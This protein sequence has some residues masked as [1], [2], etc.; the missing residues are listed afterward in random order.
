MCLQGS[1]HSAQK[2]KQ[3]NAFEVRIS[4]NCCSVYDIKVHYEYSIREWI[5]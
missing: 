2:F 4:S 5:E 1:A 3:V